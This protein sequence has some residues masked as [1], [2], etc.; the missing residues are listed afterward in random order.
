MVAVLRLGLPMHTCGHAPSAAGPGNDAL[1]GGP[2]I[3]SCDGEAGTD[4][5]TNCET[6]TSVP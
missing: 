5:A 3:D 6:I 2:N 4:T 1:N